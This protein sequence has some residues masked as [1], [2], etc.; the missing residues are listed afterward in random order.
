MLIGTVITELVCKLLIKISL[1]YLKFGS[2]EFAKPLRLNSFSYGGVNPL[3][4]YEYSLLPSASVS[5]K[6]LLT[7]TLKSAGPTKLSAAVNGILVVREFFSAAA[8]RFPAGT[9]YVNFP[10]FELSLGSFGTHLIVFAQTFPNQFDPPL[11][12]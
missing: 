7:V 5:P 3:A 6:P 11:A 12:L 2:S 4:V 9:L 1:P 8:I 10:P